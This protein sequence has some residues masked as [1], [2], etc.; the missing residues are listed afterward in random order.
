VS[1]YSPPLRSVVVVLTLAAPVACRTAGQVARRTGDGAGTPASPVAA[2]PLVQPGAPGQESHIVTSAQ[3]SDLSRVPFTPADVEFM[4]GM[5]AH[6]GQAIEMTDLIA[7]HS[8]NGDMR[9]LGQRIALSQADEITMMK[10]WLETRH[11]EVPGPHAM[12]MHGAMLMPGMLTA[13]EMERLAAAHGASFDRL[14]LEGM[15]KHHGGALTMVEEL[16]AHPG[17]GQ[18]SDIFAFASEVDGDQ[19]ME[20]ARMGAMLKE[21]P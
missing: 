8:E 11:Q 3:A 21:L 12:H 4:Q 6:H 19:R 9:Q 15:I 14:F 7:T 17:A 10:R 5:I 2:V 16:F 1:I 20:I 18:D 13:E